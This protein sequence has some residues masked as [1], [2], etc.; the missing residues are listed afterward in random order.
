MLYFNM[1]QEYS[2]SYAHWADWMFCLV[3]TSDGTRPQQGI[4]F[5]LIDLKSPGIIIRPIPTM[6]G[7][8]HVNEV[9]LD[10]VRVPSANLV[11]EEGKGWTCAKFLLSNE[12]T[13]CAET[14]KAMRQMDRLK[15][16]LRERTV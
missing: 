8:R 9:F 14:G 13:L 5:L 4:S 3:R 7:C 2:P 1:K 12:C 10:N 15:E 6:D 11:G 16:I